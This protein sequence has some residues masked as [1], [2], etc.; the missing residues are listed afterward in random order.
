MTVNIA[1]RITE[2]AQAQPDAIAISIPLAGRG[3]DRPYHSLTFRELEADI[4]SAARGFLDIGIKRGDRVSVFVKPGL[5]LVSICFALYKIGAVV[6]LIDPGMGRDG[7][8]SCI[9]RIAPTALIGIPKAMVA[10]LLFGKKFRS[11][12]IKVTVGWGAWLW[13]GYRYRK[14]KS[15]DVSPLECVSTTGSDEASILFTSGSTGPAKGVQYTHGIF[16]AQTDHIQKMYGIEAGEIDLPCFP[17]FGLF[18]LAMGMRIVIP[19]MDATKVA[20]ADPKTLVDA[21]KQHNITN[22]FASPALWRPFVKWCLQNDIQLP[23]LRR[24]LSAGAPIPPSLHKDFQQILAD[25]VEVFTPYG[26]TESLPVASIGSLEVLDDTQF[27]TARGNGT[28][29][30]SLAPNL[31]AKIIAI[32]DEPIAN[33]DEVTLLAQGDIGEICVQGPVVTKEYKE[34]PEQTRLAKIYDSQGQHW[35]RMGDLGYFDEQGRL[36]FCGRKSHR[37]QCTDQ[38]LMFPV[39]CESIFNQHP[40]I[41]RSALVDVDGAPVLVVECEKNQ[42]ITEEELHDIAQ[43]HEKTA[44]I[45]RF[46]LHPSFPVDVRHNAKI[47][48]L[49]LR[50]WAKTQ[51]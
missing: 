28:C 45:K 48:R 9:E 14:V 50:D 47:H 8:L 21:I 39:P 13:G 2:Q 15:S 12:R 30:G 44:R 1:N 6:V 33:W 40:S 29:V 25:G 24:I 10:T 11:V 5:E 19:D 31:T 38:T 41:H 34:E 36:W 23:T 22:A 7:L 20:Q 27:Q 26:A 16:E 37:V 18:S 49:Q 17:M 4:D 46:L 35:H 42:S 51:P 3:T 32:S 43:K